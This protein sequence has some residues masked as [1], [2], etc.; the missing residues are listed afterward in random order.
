M[1]STTASML[2]ML[3]IM[4]TVTTHWGL[5][6][7]CA[8]FC[9]QR[10][11]VSD[12]DAACVCLAC[13]TLP[14]PTRRW[15]A[16]SPRYG[17]IEFVT[18]VGHTNSKAGNQQLKMEAFQNLSNE[19]EAYTSGLTQS[20]FAHNDNDCRGREPFSTNFKGYKRPKPQKQQN[21]PSSFRKS[22]WNRRERARPQRTQGQLS[23]RVDVPALGLGD[24]LETARTREST[25]ENEPGTSVRVSAADGSW[26]HAGAERE[27]ERDCV[28]QSAV[29]AQSTLHVAFVP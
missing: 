11:D 21:T 18:K 23:D 19:K 16:S 25:A 4:R 2:L 17:Q 20:G 1:R 29:D 7:V 14:T 22:R 3:G 15:L 27:R 9:R 12:D 6:S 10:T 26:P 5:A 13:R 28:M 8:A 24:Q